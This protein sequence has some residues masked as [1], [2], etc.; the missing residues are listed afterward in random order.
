MGL[1]EEILEGLDQFGDLV[2]EKGQPRPNRVEIVVKP[3]GLR[4]VAE[5]LRSKGFETAAS[6][7]GVDY[8]AEKK[9]AVVYHLETYIEGERKLIVVLKSFADRGDP[10]FPSLIEVWPS[11]FYHEWEAYELF[12]IVFE[13]HPSLGPL[14][15]EDW[16]DIP[17]LRKDFKL[18]SDDPWKRA[19]LIK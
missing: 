12:G 7:S 1:A 19:G 15:L 3:E 4:E 11:L 5:F 6:L 18:R 16:D 2:V 13:G 10:R 17:P 14:F 9:M 8:P